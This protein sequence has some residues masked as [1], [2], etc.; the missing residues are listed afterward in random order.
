[1]TLVVLGFSLQNSWAGVFS[2]PHFVPSGDFAI[3]VEPELTLTHGAGFAINLK[4]TH[5]ISDLMNAGA[6]LGTGSGPR[7]FRIGGN[8]SFDFFPDAEGQPGIG[9]ALQGVFYRLKDSGSFEITTIPYIH[10]AFMHSGNEFEPFLAIPFG[11]A[12][13]EG[14]STALSSIVIGS[15]FKASEKTRFVLEF[16]VAIN[17][18]DSYIAGGIVYYH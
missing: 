2:L 15:L 5:G 1:M 11:I 4:Y 3:G 17:N 6:I 18:T 12:T 13:G 14:P 8:V 10:K 7:R 16:G 9:L